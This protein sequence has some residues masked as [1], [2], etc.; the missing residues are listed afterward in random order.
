ME[1]GD[2]T[3]PSSETREEEKQD[4]QVSAHA[5]REPTAEEA[6]RADE[7]EPDPEAAEHY[8]E[9]AERGAKQRGEGRI[10]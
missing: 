3:R 9:M 2:R 8:K 7:I 1:N 10:E 6:E 4:A 5:D